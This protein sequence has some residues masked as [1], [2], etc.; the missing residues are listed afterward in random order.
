MGCTLQ[1]QYPKADSGMDHYS[2][3]Y[4][5]ELYTMQNSRNIGDSV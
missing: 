3:D 1:V 5:S 2:E 4:Y